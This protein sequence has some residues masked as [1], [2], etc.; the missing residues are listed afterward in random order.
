MVGPSSP[1]PPAG[2]HVFYYRHDPAKGHH[3]GCA[4]LIS[5][6]QGVPFTL[7]N[8]NSPLEVVAGR[9]HLQRFY[10][11]VSFYLPPNTPVDGEV[12][13]SLFRQFLPP[14]LVLGDFNGRHPL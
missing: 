2:Y 1:P 8:V 11:I 7:F 9:I 5:I 14:F 13:Y 10:T 6:A 3:G 12:F 4:I